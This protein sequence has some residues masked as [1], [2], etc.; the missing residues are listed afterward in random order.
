[1]KAVV[2]GASGHVGSAIVRALLA[3]KYEVTAAGRRTSPPINLSGLPINYMPGDAATLHQFDRWIAGQDLVVDAAAPYPIGVFAPV[4]DGTYDQVSVAERRTRRLLEAV[5]KFNVPLIYIGSFVTVAKPITAVQKLQTE[6][7][8]LTNPYFAVKEWIDS[9]LIEASRQGVRVVI[10]SPTYC[11]GPWDLRERELCTV[12]MLLSNRIPGVVTAVLNV[13]DVRDVADA[14]LAALEQGRFGEPILLSAYRLT[15]R[16]LYSVVCELGGVKPPTMPIPTNLAI[17]GT[18]WI[19]QMLGLVGRKPLLPSAGMAI[20]AELEH[21]QRDCTIRDLGIEPRP[22]RDT[23]S[24]AISW[25]REIGH[26]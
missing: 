11:L 1:M 14:A 23:I 13:I 16:D 26:C 3:R 19:E 5:S 8:R 18:Y 22:L 9:Q 7:L 2:I 21:L 12:P 10:A 25:Y 24:A 4:I 17:L 15:T 20:A 6:M